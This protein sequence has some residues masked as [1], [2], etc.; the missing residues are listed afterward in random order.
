LETILSTGSWAR[1]RRFVMPRLLPRRL[2]SLHTVAL[3]LVIAGI[4]WLGWTWYRA[5]SFVKVEHVNVTGVSGPY[6]VQIRRALTTAALGMTTLHMQISK[7]ENAVSEYPYVKSLT[8]TRHGAHAVAI[9]VA[10][11]I[12]VAMVSVGDSSEVVDGNGELLPNTTIPH[13]ALPT[14]PI[15]SAPDGNEITAKGARGAIAV[16]AAAPYSLLAHV[17]SATSSV[18]HGVI[19]HLRNGPQVYFGP[20]DDL[21]AKWAATTSVLQDHG[22]AGAAYIDVTDPQRPAAGADVKPSQAAALGLAPATTSTSPQTGS[23]TP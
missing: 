14:V 21:R 1:E 4:G 5:S 19:L 9:T 22:S 23:E 8:V 2:R 3:I 16:L 6:V 18:N 15:S 20:T 17:E 11:Q 10:E 12:P 7:L 13:G